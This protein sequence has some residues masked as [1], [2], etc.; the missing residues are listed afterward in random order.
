MKCAGKNINMASKYVLPF[1]CKKTTWMQ[2][3]DKWPPLPWQ[4]SSLLS[5]W[6]DRCDHCCRHAGEQG[7]SSQRTSPKHKECSA[8]ATAGNIGLF[9]NIIQYS[10]LIKQS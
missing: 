3:R 2:L 7:L 4:D 5:E 1:L 10:F 8:L 9:R 6:R